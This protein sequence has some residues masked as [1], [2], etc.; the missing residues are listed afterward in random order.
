MSKDLA[1]E[2]KESV[3]N[4][5]PDLWGRIE[6]AIDAQEASK[7]TAAE[8]KEAKPDS[9]T[10]PVQFKKKKHFPAWAMAAIPMAA[11]L[12]LVLIPMGIFVP[13]LFSKGS[14]QTKNFS[15]ANAASDSGNYEAAIAPQSDDAEYYDEDISEGEVFDSVIP[16]EEDSKT[17]NAQGS[18]RIDLK[19][20]VDSNSLA[21]GKSE[22]ELN[23]VPATVIDPY[24]NEELKLVNPD[25]DISVWGSYDDDG[26][27]AYEMDLVRIYGDNNEVYPGFSGF[28]DG[29][30]LKAFALD[31]ES[32]ALLKIGGKYN[33]A[34]YYGDNKWVV[35]V[36][37]KL[38]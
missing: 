36:L 23:S 9:D 31:E 5:L 10:K 6:S 20:G 8:S 3:M 35:K 4:D 34:V 25:L 28:T 22:K 29:E 32:A 13:Q 14:S 19:P 15:M 21:Q 30:S 16:T 12:L 7:A 18:D 17:K 37:K 27:L 24:D 11:M 38:D 2:Y 1:K 26:R 33:V